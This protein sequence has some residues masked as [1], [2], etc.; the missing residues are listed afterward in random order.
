MT[1]SAQ[2]TL[3]LLWY[4]LLAFGLAAGLYGAA[5]MLRHGHEEA[6]NVT[7][8]IPWGILISSYEYFMAASAGLLILANMA[9]VFGRE[10]FRPL[11]RRALVLALFTM[12]A[13]FAIMAAEIAHPLRMVLYA[14]ISPNP[15]SPLIWVGVC[16]GLYGAVL[17]GQL[18]ADLTG[19]R[20]LLKPLGILALIV[21]VAVLT[22]MGAIL[23]VAKARPLWYGPFMP[24]YFAVSGLVS[25]GALLSLA[26]WFGDRPGRSGRNDASL[27]A[28]GRFQGLALA[29]L[30]V[31]MIWKLV[32]GLYGAP[33]GK[34]EATLALTSGPLAVNFWF[35]EILLGLV[36][37]LGLLLG[38][39]FRS[40][41][42]VMIAGVMVSLGVFA[43][44]YDLIVAGQM[45]PVRRGADGL[46][47]GLLQYSPSSIEI[48]LVVGAASLCLLLYSLCLRLPKVAGRAD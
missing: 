8:E 12:T 39:P 22:N 28:L 41:F 40:P 33:P 1:T 19:R 30:A 37:P 29:A 24:L 48:A 7:R 25:S 16:Y 38:R 42:S 46:V 27:N 20:E 2:K 3:R 10:D 44:R 21:S 23:G 36:L 9:H 43:M 32:G 35:F 47:N 31:L 18:L 6:F 26:A 34:Y 17:L 15:A 14:L 4:G 11:A 45:V 5:F 13:A